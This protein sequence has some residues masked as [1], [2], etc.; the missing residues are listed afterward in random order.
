MCPAEQ[1]TQR[2]GKV[3][4]TFKPVVL[5]LHSLPFVSFLSTGGPPLPICPDYNMAPSPGGAATT[6]MVFSAWPSL[7]LISFF[8]ISSENISFFICLLISPS[9]TNVFLSLPVSF[10]H[11]IIV[12][13]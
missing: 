5:T 10:S 9:S 12:A 3:H 1:E 4:F 7:Q 8:I 6:R 13:L 11:L 2:E